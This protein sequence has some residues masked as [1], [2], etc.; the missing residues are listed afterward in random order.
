MRTEEVNMRQDA[1]L[2]IYEINYNYQI[3]KEQ[4]VWLASSVDFTFLVVAIAWLFANRAAG[5]GCLQALLFDVVVI[6][7]SGAACWFVWYQNYLKSWAAERD[8]R[9]LVVLKR[10]DGTSKP[11]YEQIIVAAYPRE[12]PTYDEKREYIRRYGPAGK[13]LFVAMVVMTSLLLVVP[14][15]FLGL[16]TLFRFYHL[17]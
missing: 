13:G 8:S 2:K 5:F 15:I 1:L 9:I 14:W 6:L 3:Q 4:L 11:S 10:F 12:T 16:S 17:R 7:V